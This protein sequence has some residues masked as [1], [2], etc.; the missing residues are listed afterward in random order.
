[1][2]P[3]SSLQ[4]VHNQLSE[5]TQNVFGSSGLSSESHFNINSLVR[6]KEFVTPTSTAFLKSGLVQSK[7]SKKWI[8]NQGNGSSL[9]MGSSQTAS[10][11]GML[12]VNRNLLSRLIANNNGGH[13]G[14]KFPN[15]CAVDNDDESSILD[16]VDNGQ[17]KAGGHQINQNVMANQESQFGNSAGFQDQVSQLSNI[18]NMSQLPHNAS[19]FSQQQMSHNSMVAF[20]NSYGGNQGNQNNGSGVEALSSSMSN[21]NSNGDMGRMGNS[22][23]PAPGNATASLLVEAALSSVTNLIEG[24]REQDVNCGGGDNALKGR[25]V[26]GDMNVDHISGQANAG[27]SA[28]NE[29]DLDGHMESRQNLGASMRNGSDSFNDDMQEIENEVK[30]MKSLNNFQ[31]NQEVGNVGSDGNNG[32]DTAAQF[33]LSQHSSS[34]STN[35]NQNII[36]NSASDAMHE[37]EID[38]DNASTPRTF[39]R[40]S[41]SFRNYPSKTT[42]SPRDISPGQDYSQSQRPN[43]QQI[44]GIQGGIMGR[45]NNYP[46]MND[47]V[48]AT[49]SPMVNQHNSSPPVMPRYG[50]SLNDI[51][52][53]R[54]YNQSQLLLQDQQQHQLGRR[55]QHLSSDEDSIMA[56]NLSISHSNNSHN[57]GEKLKQDQHLGIYNKYSDQVPQHLANADLSEQRLKFNSNDNLELADH[58]H[59]TP[60]GNANS[61]N[62]SSGTD[63]MTEGLD[64]TSRISGYPHHNFQLSAAAAA[65][66]GL[67]RYHHHIY[68]I[69]SEREQQP[70]SNQQHLIQN[71]NDHHLQLQQEQQHM[72]LAQQHQHQNQHQMS[73][74]GNTLGSASSNADMDGADQTTSVDLSRT[75][76]F[77]VSSPPAHPYPGHPHSDMLR[78]V[79]MELS[80][81][82]ASGALPANASNMIAS[83][84]H[85]PFLGGSSNQHNMESLHHHHHHRLLS[86][87]EHRLLASNSAAAAEQL[88]SGGANRILVDPAH[89]LMESNNRSI[90]SATADSRLMGDRHMVQGRDYGSYHHQVAAAANNYHHHALVRPAAQN[91]HHGASNYHPFPTYY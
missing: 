46:H 8:D 1:M 9:D 75:T 83:N 50:F 24:S 70:A 30:L 78:M 64:M 61:L 25:Q 52:R 6:N 33:P 62:H 76:S 67:N 14:P 53:K 72:M 18:S 22:S 27:S 21:A 34:S 32:A 56:Q 26:D 29:S 88:T 36:N 77:V 28:N 2:D 42:P 90:L 4:M 51:C 20:G 68:D 55:D 3:Q 7:G 84:N 59:R 63:Q 79:S 66:A 17:G 49:S 73:D 81:G 38:V 23:T 16:V 5:H 35:G 37:N 85:R 58:F 11:S 91:N 40:D 19:A 48:G 13:L 80:G 54:D 45:N 44:Y 86:S 15:S 60:H 69:L 71:V 87:A 12:P 82:N 10:P 43:D 31:L 47:Q 89:L 74:Q 57:A 39:D 41:T 65:A